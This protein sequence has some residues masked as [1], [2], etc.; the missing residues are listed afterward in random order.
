MR[1]RRLRLFNKRLYYS[2]GLHRFRHTVGG[3]GLKVLLPFASVACH[4][5]TIKKG[6][7]LGWR[8][9]AGSYEDKFTQLDWLPVTNLIFGCLCIINSIIM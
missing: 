7:Q 4:I 8:F 6:A 5:F 1:K 2:C 9:G 3:L